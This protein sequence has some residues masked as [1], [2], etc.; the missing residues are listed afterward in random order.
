MEDGSDVII[1]VWE[2]NSCHKKFTRT[3]NLLDHARTHKG[4]KPYECQYWKR[5]YTQ[6]GNLRKHLKQ[7]LEPTLKSRKKF[8]CSLWSSRYTE[9]Y[10]YK[11][12]STFRINSYRSWSLVAFLRL[13]LGCLFFH[14]IEIIWDSC[15]PQIS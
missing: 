2:F 7:H 13:V 3:W 4:I 9:K 1:Y 11:V 10:N 14:N 8:F 12:N 5:R 15:K 6:K